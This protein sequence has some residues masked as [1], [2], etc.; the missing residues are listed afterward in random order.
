MY[1]GEVLDEFSG[2]SQCPDFESACMEIDSAILRHTTSLSGG[3]DEAEADIVHGDGGCGGSTG[4]GQVVAVG[5]GVATLPDT[6][7][8]RGNKRLR[9]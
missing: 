3:S 1:Q 9:M 8:T 6:G 7:Q 2:L 5:G 4:A